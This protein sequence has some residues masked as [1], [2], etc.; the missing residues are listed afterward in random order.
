MD[1]QRTDTRRTD[2]DVVI[3]EWPAG[4]KGMALQSLVDSGEVRAVRL[5]R[6]FVGLRIQHTQTLIYIEAGHPHVKQ[7]LP[8]THPAGR[9]YQGTGT[10]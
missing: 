9:R 3:D 8:Q 7:V 10:A 2:F 5:P 4:P 6:R 1:V